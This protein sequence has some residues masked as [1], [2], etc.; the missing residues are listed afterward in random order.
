MRLTLH[1]RNDNLVGWM[2]CP[3]VPRKGDFLLDDQGRQWKIK[4][5]IWR[6]AHAWLTADADDCHAVAKLIVK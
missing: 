3:V 5:V 4:R 1:D 6:N 2:D